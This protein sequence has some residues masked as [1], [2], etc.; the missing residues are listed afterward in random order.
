MFF[1][2]LSLEHYLSLSLS[3]SLPFSLGLDNFFLSSPHFS[4]VT[5]LS[6]SFSLSLSS[7]FSGEDIY[8]FEPARPLPN[9]QTQPKK[10]TKKE[11]KNILCLHTPTQ[12]QRNR[13]T[14]SIDPFSSFDSFEFFWC[15]VVAVGLKKT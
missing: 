11:S 7:S 10:K 13:L 5:L 6:P 1:F 4:S 2:S 12:F 8:I 9:Q 14:P 15:A 3:L